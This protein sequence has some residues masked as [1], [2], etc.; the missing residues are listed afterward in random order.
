[1]IEYKNIVPWG[2]S[3]TEYVSMFNLT[4][5]FLSNKVLGC[6]DGPAA[7]NSVA[8]AFGSNVT[9]IDP[10]YD[11]S[12]KDIEKR[13][14]ETFGDVISQTK[15]NLDKF[16]WDQ[17]GS[18]EGLG[19]IR[20]KSMKQFLNDYEQGKEEGRY[21]AASL[22]EIPFE[23]NTFD[24]VLSSHFLLL[25]S[26]HLD[27]EFHFK[28]I[29]EMLRVGK[30]LRIFPIVDLNSNPSPYIQPILDKYNQSELVNVNYE[31]QIGG[32]QMMV[33]RRNEQ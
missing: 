21:I 18:L 12:Q 9:S 28:A 24:L 15:L 25:Y 1:M 10:I 14:N 3:Y 27:L 5:E 16:K 32:N 30:E 7:F 26:D 33:I 17:F 19:K 4:P 23:N 22:P 11:L 20:M 13:I 29:D 31:F 6:G 8:T 2:R